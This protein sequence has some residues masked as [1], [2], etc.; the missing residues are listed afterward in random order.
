M[1]DPWLPIESPPKLDQTVDAQVRCTGSYESSMGLHANLNT[2]SFIHAVCIEQ[3]T[4]LYGDLDL[5]SFSCPD[6]ANYESKTQMTFILH[7]THFK[8]N[9]MTIHLLIII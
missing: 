7:R 6:Q 8:T 2:G 4:S 5:V 1:L 9:L 3:M